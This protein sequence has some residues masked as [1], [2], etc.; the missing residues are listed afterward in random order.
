MRRARLAAAV[1]LLAALAAPG[2]ARAGHV[3]VSVSAAARLADT[4]D[5][6]AYV[7]ME[8][9]T[10]C[11]VEGRTAENATYSVD[12]MYLVD[13]D[14]GERIFLG[15]SFGPAS[16]TERAGVA[17]RAADRRMAATIK[18]RCNADGHESDP[19]E[20]ASGVVVVPALE[21]DPGGGGGDGSGGGGG[22]PGSRPCSVRKVGTP[23]ADTLLGTDASELL[24]GL[25]GR[26]VLR[27]DDGADCLHGGRGRDRLFGGPGGDRLEGDGGPDLLDG[28]SGEN[29]YDG[30]RGRDRVRAR[31]RVAESVRCGPGR[32]VAIVDRGDV[33]VGCELVRRG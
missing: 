11:L 32:D 7:E 2:V 12:G 19:V 27:G 17:R 15:G 24:L 8:W 6:T 30:G 25:A 21:R 1:V 4:T 13:Q 29:S 33:A 18:A 22:G 10:S 5:S 31:N 26:D 16:G 3:T 28:G 14:T 20:E 9:S 23:R